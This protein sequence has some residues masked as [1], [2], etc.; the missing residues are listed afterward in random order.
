MPPST[1]LFIP[2]SFTLPTAFD[3]IITALSTHNISAR[4]LHLPSIGLAPN[5]GRSGPPP[6]M[7]SD[8]SF[9]AAEVQKEIDQGRDVTLI[10]HSYGGV[11]AT[12][13]LKGLGKSEREA[14]AKKGG[15]VRLGYISALVPRVGV[16]AG[17]VMAGV[18]EE[19]NLTGALGVDENGWLYPNP[20]SKCAALLLS[21]LP[22]KEAESA[23]EGLARQSS[24]S[25]G[26]A[27]TYP[28]YKNVPVSYL[29]CEDDQAVPVELQREEIAMVEQESGKLVDVK[30]I[31]TGHCPHITAPDKVVEWVLSISS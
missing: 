3:P 1:V 22:Q 12:E 7:Y 30:T 23:M 28:G 18:P 21:D 4:A 8:A 11:P 9:I 31:K 6:S 20:P 24:V 17:E 2:G 25:F 15:V 19:S 27:L 10:A 13:S 29:V 26:G 16:A 14:Q 5:T